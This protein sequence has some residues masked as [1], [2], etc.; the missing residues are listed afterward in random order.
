ME[1]REDYH[2]YRLLA[3]TEEDETPNRFRGRVSLYYE[4][5]GEGIVEGPYLLSDTFDTADRA[6]ARAIV[7][8]KYLVDQ[9]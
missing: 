3:R 6:L 1:R 8:G 9:R 5:G 2:G 4:R 7:Y